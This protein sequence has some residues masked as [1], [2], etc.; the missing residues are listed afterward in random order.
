MKK[1]CQ[2]GADHVSDSAQTGGMSGSVPAFGFMRL[3]T[4]MCNA[5]RMKLSAIDRKLD[6]DDVS[7]AILSNDMIGDVRFLVVGSTGER[8]LDWLQ[9]LMKLVTSLGQFSRWV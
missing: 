1:R 7:S 3:S 4:A 6:F 5:M 2:E 9:I 8:C